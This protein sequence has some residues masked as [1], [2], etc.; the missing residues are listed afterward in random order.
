MIQLATVVI[1]AILG[2]V[3]ALGLVNDSEVQLFTGLGGLAG[4][5]VAYWIF[6]LLR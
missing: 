4:V 2:V 5:A 6:G 3:A 1:C